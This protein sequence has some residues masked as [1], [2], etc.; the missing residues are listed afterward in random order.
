LICRLSIR[1]FDLLAPPNALNA[2][3]AH[4]AF[5]SAAGDLNLRTL[6]RVPQFACAIDGSVHA[7]AQ[8]R[9]FLNGTRTVVFPASPG[10]FASERMG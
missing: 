9:V 7:H 1:G 4:Q 5:D 10:A 6:H 8:H 2:K 3:L